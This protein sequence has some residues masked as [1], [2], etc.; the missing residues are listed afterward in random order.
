M[1]IISAKYAF[2]ESGHFYDFS[3]G[4]VSTISLYS[5]IVSIIELEFEKNFEHSLIVEIRKNRLPNRREF[6]FIASNRVRD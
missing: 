2:L 3:H 1:P 5:E 6:P 4:S